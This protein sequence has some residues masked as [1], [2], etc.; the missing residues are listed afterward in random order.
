MRT[1]IFQGNPSI[2]DLDGFLQSH[3][4]DF[5]WLAKQHRDKIMPGDD[6]YVWRS[7]GD[8]RGTAGIVAKATVI[9]EPYEG[10]DDQ[11]SVPYWKYA[12]NATSVQCRVRIR[13]EKS[14][15]SREIIKR[16]WLVEDPICHDLL[17]IRQPAGTNYPVNQD[18]ADRLGQL[19]LRTGV[20]WSRAESLAALR[21]Y[22]YTLNQEISRK[23]GSPVAEL[24]LLTGRS[25]SGVYNKIMNFRAID[26]RDQRAGL[27]GGSDI[28]R[29]VWAEFF[30]RT[31]RELNQSAIEKEFHSLWTN[32]WIQ[33]SL[34]TQSESLK[35]K[36]SAL[37]ALSQ[38]EL[39]Q[40]IAKRATS[41]IPRSGTITTT[42]FDRDPA[43]IVFAKTRA[44]FR[45]EVPGCLYQ[46]FLRSDGEA[47]IEV[48]HIRTLAS[49]GTD[50]PDNVACLCPSHHREIHFGMEGGRLTNLLL[51][52]RKR[53][54]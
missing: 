4:V 7:A 43:V 11:V 3:P 50:I 48:H 40:R 23:R 41:D 34:D 14:A 42:I 13:L 22:G 2:F 27:K 30:D 46:L 20:D 26:P 15:S 29:A 52:L 44:Q 54:G 49:G 33:K 35:S 39:L 9:S 12:S 18:Q 47:F 36:T 24:A 6:V 37:A 10:P 5:S 32:S 38:Q 25:V 8:A 19:W 16:D 21:T 51:E 53:S 1:W 17:V 28:D 45:C 31:S